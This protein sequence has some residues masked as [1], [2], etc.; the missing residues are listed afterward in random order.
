MKQS[1]QEILEHQAKQFETVLKTNWGL[2]QNEERNHV[3]EIVNDVF[4]EC[5]SDEWA[6]N[7]NGKI[8]EALAQFSGSTRKESSQ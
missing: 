4:S 8:I 1:T 3:L 5:L 7:L 2:A 6:E